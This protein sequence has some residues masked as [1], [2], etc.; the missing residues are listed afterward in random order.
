M[1]FVTKRIHAYLDYPVA[2]ALITL[3]FLLGLGDPNPLAL[4]LSVV[5]GIAA[6]ILTL[7][8][9]HHLGAFKVISYKIHLIV[10]FI[11][12]VVF[13]SAPFIFSFEGLDAYYYW[14]NGIAVL[15]VVG[16]HKSELAV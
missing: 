15:T 13:V 5:T 9:D 10:D 1:K 8:T 11:V 6:F 14:I 12:A 4:Q 16:L 2:I 7:L 3:P